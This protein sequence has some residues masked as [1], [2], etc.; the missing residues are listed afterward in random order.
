MKK[1]H[2]TESTAYRKFLGQGGSNKYFWGI[3]FVCFL[4]HTRKYYSIVLDPGAS[5]AKH[6]IMV[7]DVLYVFI[8]S[9]RESLVAAYMT[10]YTELPHV[11]LKSTYRKVLIH[12]KQGSKYRWSLEISLSQ[13]GHSL[14]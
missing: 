8:S 10:C 5:A 3:R 9:P 2:P 14:V 13:R 11:F 4:S 6:V 1:K 7:K 12:P